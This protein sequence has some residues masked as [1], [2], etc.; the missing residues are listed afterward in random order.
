MIQA[1]AQMGRSKPTYCGICNG[2]RIGEYAAKTI[3]RYIP[4]EIIK[5]RNI[6]RNRRG[7]FIFSFMLFI[8]FLH[9]YILCPK[10]F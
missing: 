2:L 5:T 8:H 1:M 3:F 9:I 7:S 10:L 6:I 4:I